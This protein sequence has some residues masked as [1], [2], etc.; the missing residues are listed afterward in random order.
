VLNLRY[1]TPAT[2]IGALNRRLRGLTPLFAGRRAEWVRQQRRNRWSCASWGHCRHSD[3]SVVRT[4]GR[5]C[6]RNRDRD[7]LS[8][9][10]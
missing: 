6:G 7:R 9:V 10:M 3:W 4:R 8:A 1:A 2:V 5:D